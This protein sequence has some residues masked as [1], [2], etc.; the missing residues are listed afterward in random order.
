MKP[1]LPRRGFVFSGC[2]C[3]AGARARTAAGF[4]GALKFTCRN[5]ET[6]PA[7]A[8]RVQTAVCYPIVDGAIG[9]ADAAGEIRCTQQ[10]WQ[11]NGHGELL[12]AVHLI[13]CGSV[14]LL[15]CKQNVISISG[16]DQGHQT[17]FFAEVLL[18]D[19]R[20]VSFSVCFL[21]LLLGCCL[22]LGGLEV[23]VFLALDTLLYQS[24]FKMFDVFVGFATIVTQI[25]ALSRWHE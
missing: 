9:Y 18:G 24:A 4:F 14:F 2:G 6:I 13:R 21:G 3:G 10:F 1:R 20:D 11:W 12:G 25:P 16:T 22:L 15:T 17:G 23:L 5:R 8:N 7:D 19:A